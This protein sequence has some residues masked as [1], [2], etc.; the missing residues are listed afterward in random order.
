MELVRGDIA[1][2]IVMERNNSILAGQDVF[3]RKKGFGWKALRPDRYG[4]S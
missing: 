1:I 4:G 2:L 3:M